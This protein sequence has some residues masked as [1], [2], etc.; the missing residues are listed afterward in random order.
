MRRI[1]NGHGVLSAGALLIALSLLATSTRTQELAARRIGLIQD[2]SM[3]HAVFAR[4]G[5]VQAM[6]AAQRD[7]R[8]FQVW[9]SAVLAETRAESL[10][11]G[12]EPILFPGRP[13]PIKPRSVPQ[14]AKI[15]WS[16]NL[17]GGGPAE[18]TFPAKYSFDISATPDCTSDFVVFP[19][20]QSPNSTHENLVAFNN[21]YSGTLPSSGMCNRT[22]SA[23][24]A[25]TSATVKWSYAIQS[26]DN[27]GVMTSPV[28]SLDGTKVAF[29]TSKS[30]QQ[31]RFH[32]L[33]WKSGDGVNAGNLQDPA[34]STAL[35]TS[36]SLLAPAAG[37][38][39]ATDL[40]F[41]ASLGGPGDTLSSPFIDYGHD[42]AYIG[43]DKGNLVRIKDVFCTVN[44]LCSG[45]TPP[46]PSVDLTWGIAGSVA[47]GAGSC[48]G[49]STS[50]LTSPVVDV[51]NTGNVY[52]GCADG[53][54]YGFDSSGV[55]LATSS[56]TVGN[57]TS[58]GGLQDGPIVDGVNGFVYE[59]SGNNGTNAV[60]V[61]AK[62]DLSSPR[63]AALGAGNKFNLHAGAFN[64]SYFSS[65]TSTNW[66]LYAQGYNGGGTQTFLY[67]IG[68]DSSRNMNTTPTSSFNTHPTASECSPLT[69]FL[70]GATDRLFLGLIGGNKLNA[71][72]I[73]A[74]SPPA[75]ALIASAAEQGGTS[76]I[77]IDNVSTS[78]QASS[79]YFAP[80][81]NQ[82][83]GAGGNGR[84][85]T[86]LT[87]SGL[88]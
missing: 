40:A 63:T 35:I 29:V 84:C 38:G 77:I 79:I 4:I 69:E 55:A 28:L 65:T 53:K 54:V 88:Q 74:T 52:V 57:N 12:E 25:G 73:T 33:A 10:K 87:Q 60:V 68:F 70:N 66:F 13:L 86:K 30:G 3:H 1:V 82:T 17:G 80:L 31:P 59:F 51:S 6:M 7:P 50:K 2:W 85:A 22:T 64:D 26:S 27:A 16:I 19:V 42:T 56:L 34:G 81:A 71:Y 78:A 20:N 11:F 58:T 41:G 75:P 47:V 5:P 14:T 83:C 44:V 21:L 9:Q 18:A 67:W 39:A 46:A 43:D 36:F 8:A 61:Q 49:T 76:G 24:D 62:T 23:S 37:S 48:S 45:L 15:D 32:V 72:N